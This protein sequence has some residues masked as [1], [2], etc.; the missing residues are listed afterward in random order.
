MSLFSLML[1]PSAS[2]AY[3]GRQEIAYSVCYAPTSSCVRP[4]ALSLTATQ[5][6][7]GKKLQK[8]AEFHSS[9]HSGAIPLL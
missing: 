8:L 9:L 2:R 4:S 6:Y 7:N 1:C 3:A 5:L